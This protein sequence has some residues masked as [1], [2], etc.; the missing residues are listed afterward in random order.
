MNVNLNKLQY[1]TNHH[2]LAKK[3]TTHM[4]HAENRLFLSNYSPKNKTEKTKHS[5]NELLFISQ[6]L[7]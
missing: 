5:F 1:E 2:Q 7:N 3:N 6:T 4:V